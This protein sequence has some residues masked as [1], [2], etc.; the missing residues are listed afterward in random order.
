MARV[1]F[2]TVAGLPVLAAC[3]TFLYVSLK[4]YGGVVDAVAA[5]GRA[6]FGLRPRCR[7]R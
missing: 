7:P 5:T 2:V 1:A 3:S 6:R 4:R